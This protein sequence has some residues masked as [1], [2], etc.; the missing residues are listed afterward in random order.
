MS[1]ETTQFPYRLCSNVTATIAD[2]QTESTVISLDGT[3]LVGISFPSTFDGTNITFKVCDTSDGTYLDYT[4][5]AGTLVTAVAGAN[6]AMGI[7]PA[8]FAGYNYI[9]VIAVTP[10]TGD[11]VLTLKSRPL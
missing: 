4:N 7:I 10:Q 5:T 11:T 9:K 1:A 3:S 2:G 8:D 6:K